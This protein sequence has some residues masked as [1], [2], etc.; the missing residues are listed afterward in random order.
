MSTT[1]KRTRKAKPV[2]AQI[3]AEQHDSHVIVR[4]AD[5]DNWLDAQPDATQTCEIVDAEKSLE[6]GEC[7]PGASETFF[8]Q[9]DEIQNTTEL[10]GTDQTDVNSFISEAFIPIE[11]AEPQPSE[12]ELE[13]ALA[14]L[15]LHD[16]PTPAPMGITVEPKTEAEPQSWDA[17]LEA[18]PA[19]KV[20]ETVFATAAAFDDR[21][22]FERAKDPDNTNIQRTLKK[23]RA[24]MVTRRAAQVML[25]TNVDPATI[26][27]VFHEGSRYN[28]YALGKLADVIFGLTKN[29]EHQQGQITNAINLACMRSLFQFRAA[30]MQFTGE[31]AKAAASDKIRVEAAIR[32][33]LV[34]HTVSAS[35]APT[36]AS[37]TMQALTTLGIV[38]K[39]GSHRNPTFDLADT[40]VV[41]KLHELLHAAA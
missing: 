12:A 23:A 17:T 22:A 41:A 20:E 8:Q 32:S 13:V 1:R 21:S 11:T 19:D 39:S 14:S 18:L 30:G 34:R 3:D 35:T 16:E 31:L 7:R 38:K 5:L 2:D 36:Q 27:R 9:N 28:V 26:N 25:A 10:A 33:H 37:S 4:S 24:Q 15:E 29:P 40:P 6:P